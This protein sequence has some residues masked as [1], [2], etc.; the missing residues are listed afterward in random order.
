LRLRTTVSILLLALASGCASSG[1]LAALTDRVSRLEE[2]AQAD[3]DRIA[4]L[5]A[6]FQ[7]V[8]DAAARASEAADSARTA[9]SRADEAARRADAMFKK[10]VSK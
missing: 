4:A 1:D 3:A 10:S 5:E 2:R 7:D 9:A 6:G 8:R